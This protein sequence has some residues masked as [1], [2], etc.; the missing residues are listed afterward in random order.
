MERDATERIFEAR[1]EIADEIRAIKSEVLDFTEPRKTKDGWFLGLSS[2]VEEVDRKLQAAITREAEILEDI[3]EV[4]HICGGD[5]LEPLQR[6]VSEKRGAIQRAIARAEAARRKAEMKHHGVSLVEL[7]KLPEVVEA[8]EALDQARSENEA[9][10][11][12]LLGRISRVFAII[13]KY[14]S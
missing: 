13:Q 11:E 10:I 14:E 12:E 9:D 6:A 1:A 5:L 4:R 7:A 3:E 2:G 8:E